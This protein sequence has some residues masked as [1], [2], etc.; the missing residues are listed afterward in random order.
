MPRILLA[1]QKSLVI[2]V[3]EARSAG[4]AGRLVILE[5]DAV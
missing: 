3:P 5:P 1:H 4:D 2:P